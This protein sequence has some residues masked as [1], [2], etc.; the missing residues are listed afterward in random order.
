MRLAWTITR[1]IVE[2]FVTTVVNQLTHIANCLR[3]MNVACVHRVIVLACYFTG[4]MYCTVIK[5]DLHGGH[6]FLEM[7]RT[8]VHKRTSYCYGICVQ[9]VFYNV[10]LFSASHINICKWVEQVDMI[11]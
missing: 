5:V 6:P 2:R 11:V 4:R 10:V 7:L 1:K 3:H 8:S 9:W